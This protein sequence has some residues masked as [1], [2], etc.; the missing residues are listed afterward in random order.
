MPEPQLE[1]PKKATC[2][3]SGTG[4][5]QAIVAVKA[6]FSPAT[7]RWFCTK[8]DAAK[9]F[10]VSPQLFYCYQMKKRESG[11]LCNVMDG[12]VPPPELSVVVDFELRVTSIV[13]PVGVSASW[14][15]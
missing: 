2:F 11:V 3:A 13:C 7:M 14:M 9:M 15:T 5:I 10:G 1:S 6:F 12:N 8:K 4:Q